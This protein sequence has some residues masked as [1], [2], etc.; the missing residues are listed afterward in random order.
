MHIKGKNA[1]ANKMMQQTKDILMN[2]GTGKD[3][4]MQK[5]REDQKRKMQ[6]D[7]KNKVLGVIERHEH[8][9]IRA[10]KLEGP[11]KG[12]YSDEEESFDSDDEDLLNDPMLDTLYK[13]ELRETQAN[14]AKQRKQIQNQSDGIGVFM[15]VAER[16]CL[17]ICSQNSK[18]VLMFHLPT[19]G[20]CNLLAGHYKE[21]AAKFPETRFICVKADLAKWLCDKMKVKTLPTTLLF[22]DGKLVD[23]LIGFEEFGDGQ[24]GFS[25][26]AL[27]LRL[28]NGGV[29]PNKEGKYR[30]KAARTDVISF[31]EF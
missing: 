28:H 15:M 11:R 27:Q 7:R 5:W 16:E 25:T 4:E 2:T 3:K 10:H 9:S 31:G 30:K 23:K 24:D 29:I 14:L 6:K 19:F 1:R 17:D 26:Y 21:L 12:E 20:R 8:A 13:G 18:V 22:D